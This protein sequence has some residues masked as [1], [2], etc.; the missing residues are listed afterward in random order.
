MWK[1]FHPEIFQGSNKR[2]NYF[3]GWYYK[4]IDKDRK[5]VIALIPGVAL[6]KDGTDHHAFVQYF[7]AMTGQ[8]AYLRYPLED[9]EA[10]RRSFEVWIGAS[11]FAKDR[12][13]LDMED[14]DICIHGDLTF[15]NIRSYPSTLREPGI[16][17]PFSFVPFMECYHGIV[18]IHHDIEGKLD[19]NGRTLD[20][21]GGYGYIEK[22]WGRSF[23]K[24]WVW[25]QSNHFEQQDAS[26]MFS[27]ADIP[28]GM[29]SFTGFLCFLRLGE[30]FYRFA[31]YSGAKIL[32]MKKSQGMLEILI[33]DRHHVLK[34][35]ALSGDTGKLLAPTHGFMSRSIEESISSVIHVSMWNKKGEKI[36]G[37]IGQKAGLEIVDIQKLLM[38]IR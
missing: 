31:T 28:W 25:M 19:I 8:T 14:R 35:R 16:M 5:H 22:D 26:F 7:D 32:S 21:T 3:E 30:H 18:N 6:G 24:A 23:P 4:L 38:K 10:S 9:F 20:L 2:R 29:S 13:H 34:I 37:G 15:K 1:L 36:F 12:I 17:G 27:V 11:F 33:K